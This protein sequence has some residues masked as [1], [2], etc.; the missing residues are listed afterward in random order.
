MSFLPLYFILCFSFLNCP[1]HSTLHFFFSFW[2]PR[3]LTFCLFHSYNLPLPW[4][5]DLKIHLGGWTGHRSTTYCSPTGS[6]R[7]VVLTRSHMKQIWLLSVWLRQLLGLGW[8]PRGTESL[9]ILDLSRLCV[10][11][12]KLYAW[13]KRILFLERKNFPLVEETQ[14]MMTWK[15][16]S[17]W[18]HLL[19]L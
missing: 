14:Y 5:R 11:L 16:H 6:T 1:T 2:L 15:T 13:P 10:A 19:T 9:P 7:S 17:F 8:L 12:H 3:V 18:A 4:C